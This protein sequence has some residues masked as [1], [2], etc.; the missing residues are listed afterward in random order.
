MKQMKGR[1]STNM[2][3]KKKESR[4]INQEKKTIDNHSYLPYYYYKYKDTKQQ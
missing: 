2:R 4:N 3:E 1:K